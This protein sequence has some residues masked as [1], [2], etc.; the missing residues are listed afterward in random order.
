MLLPN[1]IDPV[2]QEKLGR[3]ASPFEVQT[4]AKQDPQALA[5]LDKTYKGYDQNSLSGYLQYSGVDPSLKSRQNLAQQLGVQYDGSESSNTALLGKIKGSFN[6]PTPPPDASQG[7]IQGASQGSTQTTDSSQGGSVSTASNTIQPAQ[8]PLNPQITPSQDTYKPDPAL[9]SSLKSY[10]GVQSQIQG[11]DT[12]LANEL[13]AKK[14]QVIASG[15]IVNEAQLMGEVNAEKAPLIAQRNVLVGQQSTLGKT[16]Q[17]LLAQ[18]RTSRASA[19][20]SKSEAD[21]VA[22]EN[23]QL[24]QRGSIAGATQSFRDTQLSQN[25]ERIDNQENQFTQKLVQS[26]WKSVSTTSYDDYGQAHKSNIWVQNPSAKVGLDSNGKAVNISRQSNGSVTTSP[27][28]PVTSKSIPSTMQM[29]TGSKVDITTPGYTTSKVLWNNG[30]KNINTQMTQS[31]ID[32]AAIAWLQGQTVQGISR[33]SSGKGIA[34][35]K[36]SAVSERLGQLDPGGNIA[37]N[38]ALATAY[39]DAI[40]KQIGYT[41]NLTASLRSAEAD[42][43]QVVDTYSKKGINDYSSPI[44][45]IID[46]ARKY[47]LGSGD[48]S[49]FKASLK[50]ISRQYAQVFATGG[51]VQGTNVTASDILDGNISLDNLKKVADQLQSLGKIDI[52]QRN[53]VVDETVSKFKGS[54]PGSSNPQSSND[55]SSGSDLSSLRT[56]YNY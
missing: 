46:N 22:Y 16:Y 6:T 3:S 27:A 51:S 30:T 14:Q 28:G 38:K 1:N 35:I 13:Q 25:Q 21:K 18:D 17:A 42:L 45:N 49:A 53:Q 36:S 37:A 34:G 4:F 26:G 20:K 55:T 2:F 56:K 10:Q 50:E 48:V 11:I 7:T 41:T 40:K 5:S 39:A 15:G 54:V 12:A 24:A 44:S 19:E 8:D 52:D 9:D 47:N 23:A 29:N 43:K 33:N 31:A 32:I